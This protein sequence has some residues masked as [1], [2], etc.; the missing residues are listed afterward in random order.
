MATDMP[1]AAYA[2]GLYH[3]IAAVATLGLPIYITETGICDHTTLKRPAFFRAY[4]D[5][6]TWDPENICSCLRVLLLNCVSVD[7]CR[8]FCARDR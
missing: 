7:P 4:L 2:P 6:V 1:F 3:A 8:G 5:E